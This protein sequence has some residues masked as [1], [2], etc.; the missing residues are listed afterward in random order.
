MIEKIRERNIWD[1]LSETDLPIVLYGMGDGADMVIS[2]L[3]ERNIKFA[4]IFAS[5][6]FVRGQYFHGKRVKTYKE[7]E[8]TYEDFFIVMC[9]AVRDDKT[10][11]LVKKM[12]AKHPL[13]SPN[14]PI[15]NDGLFTREYIKKHDKEFDFAFS[16][17]ADEESR[18]N[19]LDILNFKVSGKIEYLF[20][21]EKEKSFVYKNILGAN[22]ESV[23]IDLGA[24][25]GDTV[26]EFYES[27]SGEYKKIYA[28]EADEKNFKKLQK[29]TAEF[30]NIELYNYAA[31]DKNEM[32][33]FEKRNARSS[34]LSSHGSAAVE[35]HS[36]DELIDFATILK[37]DIEGS[38][39]RAIEGAKKLISV[40]KPSLYICAYHRNRDMFDLPIR[41]NKI[42]PDYKFY[43]YHHKYIPAWESNF[44]GVVK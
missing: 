33:H 11:E 24:Y 34:H 25:D 40:H 35:A 28:F 44:Y 15:V 27:T 43:F 1:T 5:D 37:M 9:F 8:E 39:A 18:K 19:Y 17:L 22:G 31:W 12:A 6:T 38:E 14:V 3:E 13:V 29:N 26:K 7:T 4:D 16:L 10:I 30:Q 2:A 21:A 36:V 42:C 41:I 32:L 23:F 20:S